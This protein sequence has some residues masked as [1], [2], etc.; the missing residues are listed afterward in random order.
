MASTCWDVLLRGAPTEAAT[1]SAQ[2]EAL[3]T[4]RELEADEAPAALPIL[5][6]AATEQPL[7]VLAV[8]GLVCLMNPS[9]A[10]ALL[11]DDVLVYAVPKAES[12]ADCACAFAHM[13]AESASHPQLRQHIRSQPRIQAWLQNADPLGPWEPVCTD[14]VRV[15]LAIPTEAQ[16]GPSALSLDD[17][18]C[19]AL[20]ERFAAFVRQHTFESRD[21]A[22]WDFCAVSAAQSDALEGLHYLSFLPALREALSQ[23]APLLHKLGT[24]LSACASSAS[25]GPG[26]APSEAFVI[27]SLL[28]IVA[29]YPPVLSEQEKQVDA[30]RRSATKRGPDDPRLAPTS[31]AQRVRRIVD[32]GL[33]PP[34]V[35]LTT[36]ASPPLY[37]ILADLFLALVTEQDAIFRGRLVQLGVCRAL[38]WLAQQSLAT[39]SSPIEAAQLIPFQALA[40]LSISTD[41]ALLY[42]V[43]GKATRAV[44]YL[45]VLFLAP[46]ASLLQVFEAALAL[47]NLSSM[48]PALATAV[49]HASCPSSEKK[50]VAESIV[51]LFLQYES[52]MLRR[53]LIE[54]LCNMAQDDGVFAY[55]SGEAERDAPAAPAASASSASAPLRLH[56]AEG[57]L[58]FL[59]SLCHTSMDAHE[60]ALAKAASGLLAMLSSSPVTWHSV[61]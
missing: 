43:D 7:R 5:A 11:C 21:A 47:T 45:S 29:A 18:A 1:A 41:P 60:I 2:T 59:L 12:D 36:R 13:L 20:Y 10:Q 44:A 31:V 27:V 28:A 39:L 25:E 33:V 22:A 38:L 15:K 61:H 14:L 37:R 46:C 9:L 19:S 4:L 57:R 40:K 32:A 54:L 26:S 50:T 24:R 52:L 51:P 17:D 49:A 6:A 3:T 23:D 48:S 30:L 53:A 8:L 58:R 42:G 16:M 56:T 35:T 34:L 55:W